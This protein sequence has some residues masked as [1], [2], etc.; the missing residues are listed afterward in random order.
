MEKH[1]FAAIAVADANGDAKPLGVEK[2]EA[3]WTYLKGAGLVDA[4]GKVQDS[5]RT[6]L[7]DKTFTL[8]EE[9][10]SQ[11]A[12]VSELLKKLAGGPCGR[13]QVPT[14]WR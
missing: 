2:S 12:D 10:A 14:H 9:F 5:L 3:I 1:Q 4:K 7:K 6:A 8:P 11:K 13:H